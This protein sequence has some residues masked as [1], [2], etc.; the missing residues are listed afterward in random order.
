MVEVKRQVPAMPRISV[1]TALKAPIVRACDVQA[2][3]PAQQFCRHP[4][5][6]TWI[7]YVLEN[8]CVDD[9]I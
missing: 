5:L 2:A 3:S 6:A 4:Q 8:V 7:A 1:K 9:A